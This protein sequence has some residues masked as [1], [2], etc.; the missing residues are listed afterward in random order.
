[1]DQYDLRV[2][3]AAIL[4]S[5]VLARGDSYDPASIKDQAL[6]L[7]NTFCQR[8]KN[9]S[10]EILQDWGPE[11]GV[12]NRAS[13]RDEFPIR[14]AAVMNRLEMLEGEVLALNLEK[15]HLESEIANLRATIV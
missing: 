4:S 3:V 5:G 2:L 10:L 12:P 6:D 1:M 8:K 13:L 7:M 15:S 11:I 9:W 14:M